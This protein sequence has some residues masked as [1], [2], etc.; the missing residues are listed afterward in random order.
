VDL[1]EKGKK[2]PARKEK[3]GWDTGTSTAFLNLVEKI[4]ANA[5]TYPCPSKV[6]KDPSRREK[7][8]GTSFSP[9]LLEEGRRGT[10]GQIKGERGMQIG[11]FD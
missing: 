6:G 1:E 3:E 4:S 8:R 7:R 5:R 9:T 10:P 2:A 11:W